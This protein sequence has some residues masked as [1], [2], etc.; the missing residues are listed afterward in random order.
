MIEKN[1][2]LDAIVCGEEDTILEVSQ[3][4]RDTQTRHIL[5]LNKEKHPIGVIS[6]VDINNRV[7]AEKKDPSKTKASDIMTKSIATIDLNSSYDDAY[8]KMIEIGT[9][10]LPVTEKG[11]LVGLL[12]FNR[13]FRKA[14]ELK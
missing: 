5:V 13:L 3:I 2:L 4:L 1:K 14:G 10:S 12:D 11:E 6:T 8:K 7:V 9:Y